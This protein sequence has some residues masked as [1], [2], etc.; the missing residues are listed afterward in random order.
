MTAAEALALPDD[1]LA[2]LY[3]T[4]SEETWAAGWHIDGATDP[5][6]IAWL[7]S[8]RCHETQSEYVVRDLAKIRAL[9][10]PE[11]TCDEPGCGREGLCGWPSPIGYRRTCYEHSDLVGTGR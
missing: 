4:Y 5:D 8:G 1:V 11:Q 10:A 2:V 7:L 6:F 9:L 3:S